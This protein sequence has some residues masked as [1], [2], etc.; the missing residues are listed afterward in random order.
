MIN[1]LKIII[2]NKLFKVCS[3]QKICISSTCWQVS[4]ISFVSLVEFPDWKEFLTQSP[5]VFTTLTISQN[6]K[7]QCLPLYVYD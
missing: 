5:T 3:L 7:K 2:S 1:L 6:R 4:G